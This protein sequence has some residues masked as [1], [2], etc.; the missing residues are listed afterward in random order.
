MSKK[1]LI[2]A[3]NIKVSFGEQDILDFDKFKV[4]EGDKIGLVGRNGAGKSTLFRVLSGELEPTDGKVELNCEPFYF[5]QF[6]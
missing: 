5:R 1:Q 6:D 2:N 3:E 4:F